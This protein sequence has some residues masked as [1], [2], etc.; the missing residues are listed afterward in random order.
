MKFTTSW[1][2]GDVKRY[3]KSKSGKST[4]PFE[5]ACELKRTRIVE[6][7]T[8]KRRSNLVLADNSGDTPSLA[9]MAGPEFARVVADARAREERERSW[10][11]VS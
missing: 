8:D 1:K 5:M 2:R 9:P 10:C 3:I 6:Y 7:M 4:T 11:T